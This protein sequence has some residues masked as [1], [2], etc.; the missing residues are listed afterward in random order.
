[1]PD[2]GDDFVGIATGWKGFDW[3]SWETPRLRRRLVSM[4]K[5]AQVDVE[6]RGRDWRDGRDLG[7]GQREL[8]IAHRQHPPRPNCSRPKRNAVDRPVSLDSHQLLTYPA[9][10]SKSATNFWTNRPLALAPEAA[11][12]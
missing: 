1:M 7:G 9:L 10:A 11:G 5:K 3:A 8:G 2:G 6:P 12:E 4:A